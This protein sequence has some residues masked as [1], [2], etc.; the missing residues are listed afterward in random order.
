[1]SES[2]PEQHVESCPPD[3]DAI[4][5]LFPGGKRDDKENGRRRQGNRYLNSQPQ[6]KK[7]RLEEEIPAKESSPADGLPEVEFVN[8]IELSKGIECILEET[9]YDEHGR[10][11][12]TPLAYESKLAEYDQYCD[13]V[14]RCQRPNER[15]TIQQYK[16]F[17]YMLYV[18]FR[19]QKKKGK[20]SKPGFVLSE[21]NRIMRGLKNGLNSKTVSLIEPK[22]GI[23]YNVMNTTKAALRRRWMQEREKGINNSTQEQVFGVTFDQL[24]RIVQERKPRRDKRM[25]V[26]KVDKDSAGMDAVEH[27]D[28]IENELFKEGITKRNCKK[29]IHCALRNRFFFLATISSLLRGESVIKMELSDLLRIVHKGTRDEHPLFILVMQIPERNMHLQRHSKGHIQQSLVVHHY[30][31]EGQG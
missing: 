17:K 22:N 24:M 6:N 14:Y 11:K 19:E 5:A 31:L 21:Y 27:I 16:V 2:T 30:V 15:Y 7:Q 29:T 23:G 12:N 4:L 26:E 9:T 3:L 10:K 28:S 1:M 18:A 13:I 8:Q 20:G 25:C